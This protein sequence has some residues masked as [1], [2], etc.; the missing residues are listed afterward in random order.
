MKN[1][2][3]L[4]LAILLSLIILLGFQYFIETP[5]MKQQ[6]ERQKTIENTEEPSTQPGIITSDEDTNEEYLELNQALQQNERL[7]IETTRLSGSI[8]LKGLKIDN[9]ILKDYKEKQ[10][11]D[12]ELVTIF[13]PSNTKGGYYSNFSW[14]NSKNQ[15]TELPND[16]TVW[17]SD[18]KILKQNETVKFTW[19]NS[20][21]IE[22]QQEISIDEN[23]LF[24]IKQSVKNNSGENIN[25]HSV[26]KISR[27]DTPKTLGYFILHEGPIGVV[28]NVLEE[29][30]YDELKDNIGPIEFSS[31]GGWFGITDKY[32]L[33]A[34]IPDQNSTVK[35]RFQY[36]KRNNKDKYQVDYMGNKIVIPT[37]QTSNSVHKLFVGA[38]EVKLLDKYE[39]THSIARFDLA[40]DFGWYYWL[41]K[42]FFYLLIYFK[43]IFGNF[44]LSILF[45]TVL[46]KAVF[47]PLANKSYIAM[48]R[49]KELQPEMLRIKELYKNDKM[50]MNQE[51]MAMYKKEKVNPAA[52]CFPMLIQIPVF[53]ALYKVLFISIEMLHAPFYGWIQDLSAADPTSIL[54]LFGLMPWDP[55]LYLPKFLNIGLWPLIM[56]VSMYVQQKLNPTPTDPMQAKIFMFLPIFFTFILA[57]FPSGLVIYWAW[58]N[59]LSMGQQILIKKRMERG[60]K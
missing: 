52:G 57:P 24:T 41:T 36:Y 56:G 17:K 23:F 4:L 39:K 59:L 29:F 12:S 9:L 37:G 58:N 33:S 51:M 34:L 45:V 19:T 53:F 3:N 44:G 27:T 22:F 47:Y 8:S 30:D 32:W 15:I 49:M 18:K 16:Q 7:K 21:N 48:N 43:N 26:A 25:I 1:Q 14:I 2:G 42:P 5:K 60:K 55:N 20:Q 10:T 11:E 13:K 38:K 6:A 50:K 54:N 46:I 31:N 35:A 40:I 28:D